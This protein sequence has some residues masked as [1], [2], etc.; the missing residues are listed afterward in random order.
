MMSSSTL[1]FKSQKVPTLHHLK[2]LPTQE[3]RY[4]AGSPVN[5]ESPTKSSFYFT[6]KGYGFAFN[7][8]ASTLQHSA[9]SWKFAK[10]P[11][12]PKIRNLTEFSNYEELPSSLDQKSTSFGFGTKSQALEISTKRSAELPSPNTY[13]IKSDFEKRKNKGKSFGLSFSAYAKNYVPNCTWVPPEIAKEY[14]GP[15]AYL[16]ANLPEPKK[17]RMTIKKRLKMFN[18]GLA[19]DV[20]PSNHYRPVTTLLESARF[21][22]ITFGFGTKH[23]FTKV[24]NDNPGPGAYKIQSN[25]DK[26]VAK[27][28]K[29]NRHASN[30]MERN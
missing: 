12:F 10:S 21:R 29:I 1:T 7:Q 14:P 4:P 28:K 8:S 17:P 23:D 24:K 9:T 2:S 13:R 25:F 5:G 22:K 18:E 3:D 16:T 27:R 20:P 19:L 30:K 11:R 15:G 6:T 26:I